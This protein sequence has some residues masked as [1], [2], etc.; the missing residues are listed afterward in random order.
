MLIWPVCPGARSR[1]VRPARAPRAGAGPP[2]RPPARAACP[3]TSPGTSSSLAPHRLIF[4]YFKTKSLRSLR[5]FKNDSVLSNT[6]IQEEGVSGYIVAEEIQ[7]FQNFSCILYIHTIYK[8][9][10]TSII[11]TIEIWWCTYSRFQSQSP[12]RPVNY[13]GDSIVHQCERKNKCTLCSLTVQSPT[14]RLS[15]TT[16]LRSGV[17]P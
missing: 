16:G 10:L 17:I 3:R 12:R 9:Q 2:P 15:D 8:I 1:W 7:E 13:S 6:V 11:S 5:S 4:T 14:E